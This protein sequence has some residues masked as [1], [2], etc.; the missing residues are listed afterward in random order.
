MLSKN[1]VK[2]NIIIFSWDSKKWIVSSMRKSVCTKL[3]SIFLPSTRT[4]LPNQPTGAW[5][6]TKETD[7]ILGRTH[8]YLLQIVPH[9]PRR[10]KIINSSVSEIWNLP[11]L[12]DRSTPIP[13]IYISMQSDCRRRTQQQFWKISRDLLCLIRHRF[14]KDPGFAF[15]SLRN[16][17]W[18]V[19]MGKA[20][21]FTRRCWNSPIHHWRITNNT[22]IK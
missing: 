9:L 3:F 1:K 4:P 15:Q 2:N 21:L 11:L 5:V 17:R 20:K 22:Q 10:N 19:Q 8:P 6:I 13:S 7:W 12:E 16:G 18:Y 14:I